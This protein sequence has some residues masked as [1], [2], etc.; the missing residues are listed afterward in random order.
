[1][2]FGDGGECRPP[3]PGP[4]RL[5]FAIVILPRRHPPSVPEE[6]DGARRGGNSRVRP[7]GSDDGFSPMDGEVRIRRP[8]SNDNSV[9]RG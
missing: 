2:D 1:M 6:E 5:L 3:P 9:G 8:I 7:D 4:H